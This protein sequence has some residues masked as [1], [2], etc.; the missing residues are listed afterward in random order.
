MSNP[1]HRFL[2]SGETL[3][4]LHDHARLLLRTQESLRG[5]LPAALSEHCSV[6]NLRDGN[7]VLFARNGSVAARLRQMV[8]SLINGFASRGQIVGAIQVK[9][10]LVF[11]TEPP[12]PPK[13]RSVSK[14]GRESLARLI[15]DL[16]EDAPL[17]AS[18]QRLL[19]RSRSD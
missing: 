12:P 19:D 10:G 13:A 18:L 9:V 16:P 14:G 7:L 2:G 8:P 3:T 5:M 4:R 15:A 17:R 11:E 1:L 6:A